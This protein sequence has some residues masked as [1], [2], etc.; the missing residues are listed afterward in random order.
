M[1]LLEKTIFH[2]YGKDE[3]IQEKF[4]VTW[5]PW[6]KTDFANLRFLSFEKGEVCQ[7]ILIVLELTW[8][9]KDRLYCETSFYLKNLKFTCLE[10]FLSLFRI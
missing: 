4:Q 6:L 3:T 8:S 9:N 1:L 5:K 2:K 7:S 10:K